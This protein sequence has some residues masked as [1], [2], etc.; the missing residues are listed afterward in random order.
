MEEATP[1]HGAAW[2]G[3]NPE[4]L[5][6][7]IAG[8]AP[9]EATT[10]T[11]ETPLHYAAALNKR[12]DI[13]ACLLEAGADIAARNMEE[14]TP[15]H[16][17]A[18]PGQNPE[19]LRALIAGGAPLEAT[20]A[21]GNT[22][23]HQ[24]AA[25]NKRADIVA[26][27]LEAGADIAARN[28][29]EAT[30]L[31]SAAG[32]SENPEV[33]RVLIAAGAPLEATTR[34]GDTPLHLAAAFNSRPDVVEC[35]LAAGA[36]P[37]AR[38]RIGR[39]PLH[40]AAMDNRNP[41]V[42]A[43]LV[44]VNAAL[45]ARDLQGRNSLHL[46]AWREDGPAMIE[47]LLALG[48][49]IEARD[50]RART[51]LHVAAW[52]GESTA[53]LSAL[54]EGGAALEATDDAGRTPLHLAL[55]RG[56]SPETVEWL[57]AE[58]AA[59]ETRN[60][61]GRAPLHVAAEAEH[62]EAMVR[63]LLAAGANAHARDGIGRSALHAAAAAA[64]HPAV[65][66][67]LLEGG[68]RLEVR[69]D[70]G[71]HAAAR[72]RALRAA[73]RDRAR[74]A[75]VRGA[76][77]R[78]L[79]RRGDAVGRARA[80]RRAVPQ[81]RAS[82]LR[83][84][85]LAGRGPLR[86][87]RRPGP[88]EGTARAQA[89]K[90]SFTPL[91]AARATLGY[92]LRDAGYAPPADAGPERRAHYYARQVAEHRRASAWLGRGAEAL[93][94]RGP[95]SGRVFEQVLGGEVPG[96][97]LVLRRHRDGAQEHRC[98]WDM[99]FSVPK[100]ISV[101]GGVQGDRRIRAAFLRAVHEAMEVAEARYLET[102]DHD[103]ETGRR[104]RVRAEGLVAAVFFHTSNR[105]DEPQ[106]HAHVIVVNMTRLRGQWRSVEPT[107]LARHARLL[108]AVAGSRLAGALRA[109]GYGIE[110]RLA[111]RAPSFEIAGYSRGLLARYSSRRR[112]I[113]RHIVQSGR[114]YSAR[115]AQ[116]AALAT[117]RKKS[118]L[119]AKA[120]RERWRE[121]VEAN[122][123]LAEALGRARRESRL[124]GLETEVPV[125]SAREAVREAVEHLEERATVVRERDVLAAALML[126][127]GRHGLDALGA[128]LER[129]CRARQLLEA[130]AYRGGRAFV[131]AREFAGERALIAW[132]RAARD[133]GRALASEAAVEA[134]LG[135]TRLT[136]GQKAAAR[137]IL[138][139]PHRA[140]AVQGAAGTGKT[141]M[142]RE[143]VG[144]A[145]NVPVF[146]LAPSAAA[147][148]VLGHEAGI[149]TRT[150]DWC[151]TRFADL[152]SGHA[153][154]RT[155]ALARALC[156]DGVLIV[157]EASMV[158]TG[159]LRALT[160]LASAIGVARTVL[161]GD[162][163]Q[164]QSVRPGV[165]FR[166]L[167]HSGM[168]T[169]HMEELVRQRHPVLRQA[170]RDALSGRPARALSYLGERLE[171]VEPEALAER[172]GREFLSLPPH[173]RARTL[174]VAPTNA[175]R[176]DIC[177]VVREGLT[178]EGVLHGPVLTLDRLIDL[179]CT[180]AEKKRL[181]TY[182]PGDEVVFVQDL[183]PYRV[184]DGEACTVTGTEDARVRLRHPD[185]RPRHFDPGG[186]IRHRIKLCESA[187][188]EIRAG[189]RIR[190]THNDKRRGLLNG[191]T[192]SV[193]AIG[194]QRVRLRTADGRALALARDDRQLRHIDHAYAST[195]HAAQGST[196]ERV[197][198]LLDADPTPLTNQL[199]FYVQIS[200]AR[201]EVRVFTDDREQ[202]IETLEAQ[203]G[204]RMSAHEALGAV[205]GGGGRGGARAAPAVTSACA[206]S[207]AGCAGKRARSATP[208]STPEATPR[209]TSG[210]WSSAVR[211]ACPSTCAASLPTGR[212][213]TPGARRA[214]ATSRRSSKT[215]RGAPVRPSASIRR[216]GTRTTRS[217]C[218]ARG[219]C[220]PT[221][222]PTVCTSMRTRAGA[223]V[224]NAPS[225]PWRRG[226]EALM[227]RAVPRCRASRRWTPS[228]Q[229]CPRIR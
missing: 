133:T 140:V 18:W 123:A 202:L 83:G 17:A 4:V 66:G 227:R 20:D 16:G 188:I 219:A 200:R 199:T 179:H 14:A 41:D 1:L 184:L 190:W 21:R 13:V 102:R 51:P 62:G 195:A 60:R 7:L 205:P 72:R 125:P 110:S 164:L 71:L 77:H 80:Q 150:V 82:R 40:R 91:G 220:T 143:V 168:P 94:L 108:G 111:G 2:P 154:P 222:W 151:L 124:A 22:P 214:S 173:E 67:A 58:G 64:R 8:G 100:S 225:T 113:V 144:L 155:R 86:R 24:A 73:S 90:V 115:A 97:G 50:A 203:S 166:L 218:T 45:E 213:S 75:R 85:P 44:E 170:V 126:H 127:P 182:Q 122:E 187:P 38:N 76:R 114:R 212:P 104:A 185:G 36:N 31:H 56:T 107:A 32:R 98:G 189:E 181:A 121:E 53:V 3:Q 156:G 178:A 134:R 49:D 224:S 106:F 228:T 206:A 130:R 131:T 162:H 197:I 176:R 78:P 152:E 105:L 186:P 221:R 159:Q 87:A 52:R 194:P 65:I 177:A 69:D 139:S 198:A 191:E 161:C 96:T 208:P 142:M 99:T 93:G 15:L 42:L 101:A 153:P 136:A 215:R 23:L 92:Y 129:L 217:G 70:E 135:A 147:A 171:E 192:A 180:G 172:A 55:W 216:A 39:T 112:E 120:L 29:E 158:S 137:L 149:E 26:C 27:L 138:L 89:V 33:L 210:S 30:P 34:D 46:A 25:L 43:A 167:Q 132:M 95:V 193:E 229:R 146:G 84:L 48:A 19:V 5:R 169:A 174:L 57:V 209:C 128:S 61:Y 12:A 59:L 119:R 74:P 163:R 223:R 145:G 79:A 175:Q 117:R 201:E 10:R 6:A 118:G 47:R 204:E 183:P 81:Q 157:D 63:V 54:V 211:R 141:A 165:P 103:P 88:G 207:G 148:R 37:R 226:S 68:A 160:R 28:M 116:A 35:L 109:L 11:G 196:C 9:L